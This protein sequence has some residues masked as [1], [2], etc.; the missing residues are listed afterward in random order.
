MSADTKAALDAALAAHFADELDGAIVTAYVTQAAAMTSFD[1]D[2]ERTQYFRTCAEG[3]S[4]H[5]TLG[6]LDYAHA[7]YRH[8]L[9]DDDDG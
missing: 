2:A 3:Q 7:R 8:D 1:F 4:A 9:M 5:V 6:I